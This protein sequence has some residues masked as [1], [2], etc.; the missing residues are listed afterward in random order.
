MTL[1]NATNVSYR[2]PQ[3]GLGLSA[4]SLSVSAG[5]AVHVNGP[6][7][8]GKSTLARCLAGFIPHLYRGD[9]D[10]AVTFHND[11]LT[12]LPL[13]Q[14][15]EHVGLVFQNPAAQMLA[16]SVEEEII[17]GLENLGLARADIEQRLEETL[18][19]FNLIAMRKRNPQT[20]S[21]GE[22]Q[23]LALAAIMARQPEVL[24]LDEPFSMLDTSASLALTAALAD[25]TKRGTAVIVCEHRGDYLQ[26]LPH[27]RTLHLNGIA[28]PHTQ[29]VPPEPFPANKTELCLTV[30]HLSVSLGGKPILQEIGFGVAGGEITAVVG[31]NGVGKTTL[32][33]ALTGLQ[34]HT[35]SIQVNGA[36]PQLGIVFQNPDLQLFNSSVREEILYRMPNPDM[37]YYHWL[38]EAMGLVNYEET[39][40]LLLSEGEKKRVALA[41]ILMRQPQHGILLDEPSLGQD[42]AHK[43]MLLSILRALA[44]SGQLVLFTTHDLWLAAQADRLILLGENGIV[45]DGKPAVLMSRSNLWQQAGLI[46]PPWFRETDIGEH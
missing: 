33:R 27:L 24:V 42:M 39:P 40:P 5:T 41:T 32:L 11:V 16:Q 6:S 3:H 19:Q 4:T 46:V 1:L 10:G 2:Y 31:Q 25:L 36:A 43:Q 12:E 14:I 15:S 38:I 44:A 29:P 26:A 9:L 23:K 21:G 18:A 17:F 7:G 8:C 30:K 45:A 37:A 28:P 22:Q 34:T 20:L 13:W 35:G